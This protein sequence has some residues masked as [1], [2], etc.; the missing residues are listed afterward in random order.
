MA[1]NSSKTGKHSKD[2]SK[3]KAA[4]KTAAAKVTLRNNCSH[5]V[6]FRMPGKT[7]RISPRGTRDVEKSILSTA[8][9]GR[10]CS[11]NQVSV[12]KKWIEEAEAAI[13][14]VAEEVRPTNN[15]N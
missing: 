12:I 2:K 10:L 8:E 3:K 14:E 4:A 5:P 7:V 13:K 6:F 1:D 9:L 11:K 15:G